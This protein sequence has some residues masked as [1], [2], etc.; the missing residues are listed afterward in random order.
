[1]SALRRDQRVGL[2]TR[3][4]GCWFVGSG[5]GDGYGGWKLGEGIRGFA[6]AV[7]EGVMVDGPGAEDGPACDAV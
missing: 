2:E 1:M 3:T 7:V 4:C 5:E 6:V